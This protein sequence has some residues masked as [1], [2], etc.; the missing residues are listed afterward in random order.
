MVLPDNLRLN[1]ESGC[2]FLVGNGIN[3][4]AQCCPSWRDLVREL[5]SDVMLD[6][7]VDS[8]EMSFPIV[9]EIAQSCREDRRNSNAKKKIEEKFSIENVDVTKL[10]PHKTLVEYAQEKGCPILTLNYDNY[11]E[12]CLGKELKE[13]KSDA[14]FRA[15]SDYRWNMYYSDKKIKDNVRKSFG[16]WHIHGDVKHKNSIRI[17]HKD[18]VNMITKLRNFNE[19][20]SINSP[21]WPGLNTWIEIFYNNN[22]IIMGTEL[23]PAETDLYW[24]LIKRKRY[25]E[26]NKL[27][28]KTYYFTDFNK[29]KD[30]YSKKVLLEKL[31]IKVISQSFD[32]IYDEYKI[33]ADE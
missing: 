9:F 13:Y 29:E 28:Y 3:L 2:A 27:N 6:Y 4:K 31:G 14:V 1:S 33:F 21:D 5:V 19:S 23:D 25:I 26:D 18:Y 32:K 7:N 22:L 17:G 20:T 8:K 11:L 24:L 10:I 12:H 30:I 15:T 16:I